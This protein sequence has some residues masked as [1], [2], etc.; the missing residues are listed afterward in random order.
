MHE[1]AQDPKPATP[2]DPSIHLLVIGCL[3]VTVLR[4]LAFYNIDTKMGLPSKL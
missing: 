3:V 4:P 2:R 1:I